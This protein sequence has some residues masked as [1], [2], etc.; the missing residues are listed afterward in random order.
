MAL[1][2]EQLN[3]ILGKENVVQR[4]FN[5]NRPTVSTQNPNSPSLSAISNVLETIRKPLDVYGLNKKIPV[6][7]GTTFA[8]VT[9][10]NQIAPLTQDVAYGQPLMRGGSLQTMQADPRLAGLVDFIPAVG[11][12]AKLGQV[13]AK[14]GAREIARQIQ[15]GTGV[16]GRNVIDPR[17][18]AYL[19]DTPSKPNPLVGTRFVSKAQ[20]NL[21]PEVKIPIEKIK[22]ASIVGTPY[23]NTPADTLIEQISDD[24]I[25]NQPVYTMGGDNFSRLIN[26]YNQNI[27][28]ASNYGM[29][30]KMNNRFDVARQE[31]LANKGTGE[32]YSTPFNMSDEVPSEAF[33]S[34]PTDVITQIFNQN[35]DKKSLSEFNNWFRNSGVQV[36]KNG[37]SVL[38]RPFGNF[39]G[40]ETPEGQAQLYTGEG[41][42]AGGT[43]GNARKNVFKGASQVNFEKMFGY[44]MKDIRGAVNV[45]E[46]VNLPKGY[47]RG[48]L[49]Q[50]PEKTI[51]TPSSLG[52]KIKAYDTD[53]G[54]KYAATINTT[55]VQYLMPKTYNRIY[56]ELKNK[57]PSYTDKALSNMTVGAMEKR[58]NNI[59]EIVDDQVIDSYYGFQ[60]GL[61]GK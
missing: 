22:G 29:A 12:A 44:N 25:L 2:Q 58:A 54:G 31:N 10:L 32:V 60:E 33:S 59:S 15:E 41:F 5:E 6:V 56:A 20:G 38:V 55:L 43:A 50:I 42:D 21:V 26:N 61:L 17:M 19:P 45:P 27:G 37:K 13:G 8:D 23:D 30:S 40:I 46:Y 28:G 3:R 11:G 51:L 36:Q 18:Y 9:G 14:A 52:S 47:A 53:T 57:Y 1:T 49:I 48:N 34:Y 4:A 35:G 24:I 16:F 7:G 39:K